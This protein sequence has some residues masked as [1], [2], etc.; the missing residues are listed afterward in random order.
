MV[1]GNQI[2]HISNAGGVRNVYH[3]TNVVIDKFVLDFVGSANGTDGGFGIYF[4]ES[5]A[6]S[7]NYGEICHHCLL[8]LKQGLSNQEITL[9]IEQL[10][11]LLNKF[12]ME[13]DVNYVE[14]YGFQQFNDDS[15]KLVADMLIRSNSNDVD[16]I[17]D[18]ANGSGNYATL[19]EILSSMGYT[20]NIDTKT[21]IDENIIHYIV[22]DVNCIQIVSVDELETL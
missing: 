9:S 21:A 14:N 20:H 17:G 12:Y 11:Q 4:T 13:Y 19:L 6:E 10:Q 15:V 18:I 22:Y 3:G 1:N 2:N 7:F 5:K 8:N 16:I